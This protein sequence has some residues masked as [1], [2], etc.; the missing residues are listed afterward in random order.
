MPSWHP[1][2]TCCH[3]LKRSS[4]GAPQGG[5]CAAIQM[6]TPMPAT[7][8]SYVTPPPMANGSTPP[9]IGGRH[10][11]GPPAIGSLRL[12]GV[13]GSVGA[14]FGATPADQGIP[15]DDPAAPRR[16][17]L[18]TSGLGSALYGGSPVDAG[19]PAKRKVGVGSRLDFAASSARCA[20]LVFNTAG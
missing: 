19:K 4:A 10:G 6:G 13:P 7:P 17:S 3:A 14:A 2:C 16:G 20:A 18:R 11:G 15:G 12:G 5:C 8:G 1:I 9:A